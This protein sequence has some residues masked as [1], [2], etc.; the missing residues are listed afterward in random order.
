MHTYC[1]SGIDSTWR[2]ACSEGPHS[3]SKVCVV[4][5]EHRHSGVVVSKAVA[6]RNCV[7]PSIHPFGL[8]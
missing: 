4:D 7:L 2:F 3:V 6:V 8:K 5:A 1:K